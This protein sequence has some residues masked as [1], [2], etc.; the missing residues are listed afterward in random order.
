MTRD[1]ELQMGFEVGYWVDM[2]AEDPEE[3][4][5]IRKKVKN[6]VLVPLSC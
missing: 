2:E 5:G 6:L 1:K 3:E 4:T